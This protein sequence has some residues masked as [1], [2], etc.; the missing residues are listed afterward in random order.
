[1]F[2]LGPNHTDAT[3]DITETVVEHL[4]LLM[5]SCFNL[6]TTAKA[7]CIIGIGGLDDILIKSGTITSDP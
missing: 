2:V 5:G 3:P 6:I 7:G 1:V 4:F